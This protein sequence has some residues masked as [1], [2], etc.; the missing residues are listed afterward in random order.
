MS[1]YEY[2]EACVEAFLENQL[3]LLPEKVAGTYEEAEDFLESC[4]AIV[5]E[6]KKEVLEYLEEEM[7]NVGMDEEEV[8][9]AEEVFDIGDGRYLV[10]EG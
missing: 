9:Q 1:S 5:C 8:L 3:Q 10:V 6:N 7:D 2:D 4:M